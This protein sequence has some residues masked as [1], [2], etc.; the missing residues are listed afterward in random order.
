MMSRRP[1]AFGS[2][3]A[4]L[5]IAAEVGASGPFQGQRQTPRRDLAFAL[6]VSLAASTPLANSH[7]LK[8]IACV[9]GG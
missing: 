2:R 4:A 8:P 1:D 6:A 5:G 3:M 9:N 7:I